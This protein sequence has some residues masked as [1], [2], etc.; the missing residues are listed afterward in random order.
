MANLLTRSQQLEPALAA[1]HL[2]G[3]SNRYASSVRLARPNSTRRERAT[4]FNT[5]CYSWQVTT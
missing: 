1:L 5:D 3:V 2:L 4:T